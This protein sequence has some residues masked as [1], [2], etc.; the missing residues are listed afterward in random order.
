MA[1]RAKK[2]AALSL[3]S[4]GNTPAPA[5]E[6]KASEAVPEGVPAEDVETEQ[7]QPG[8]PAPEAE[9]AQKAAEESAH[10]T[11]KAKADLEAKDKQ[12]A[13]FKQRESE[14][15]KAATEAV[16]AREDLEA[17]RDYFRNLF[18]GA[19]AAI[20]G[21]G[22]EIDPLALKVAEHEY[23]LAKR[24][25]VL[26]R[27]EKQTKEQAQAEQKAKMTAEIKPRIEALFAKHPALNTPEG[28][29]YLRA[30]VVAGALDTPDGL[31]T[32]A[33]AFAISRSG[34]ARAAAQAPAQSAPAAAKPAAPKAAAPS[35][36]MTLSGQGGG[37]GAGTRSTPSKRLTPS[38]MDKK[39][40]SDMARRAA[41]RGR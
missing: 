29:K 22:H 13:T 28:H 14:W 27:G 15:Q 19:R 41:A 34:A 20:E 4:R 8:A 39:I 37:G 2:G 40:V 26:S 17:E 18:H 1:D 5:L 12:I 25:R 23:E 3:V 21:L 33:A 24:D 35:V 36:P 6:Q 10:W 30:H 16:H 9:D 32:A 11:Q 31:E 38:E 7:G